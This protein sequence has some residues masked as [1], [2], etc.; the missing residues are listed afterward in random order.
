M[1]TRF[2]PLALQLLAG[3]GLG[4]ILDKVL[5]DQYKVYKPDTPKTIQGVISFVVFFAIAGM[6]WHFI[7]KK[8]KL[9]VKYR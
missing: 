1:L 6:V 9:P 2:L 4:E 3:L 5:P 8:M 7:A